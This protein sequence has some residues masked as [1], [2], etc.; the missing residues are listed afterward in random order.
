MKLYFELRESY[1]DNVIFSSLLS[2]MEKAMDPESYEHLSGGYVKALKDF[3]K[4][5]GDNIRALVRKA[6]MMKSS[7]SGEKEYR[8][9]WL[10]YQLGKG[11][12]I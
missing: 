6:Y 8:T 10:L 4:L 11:N 5:Y 3:N 2:F 9:I 7:S 1:D 12:L